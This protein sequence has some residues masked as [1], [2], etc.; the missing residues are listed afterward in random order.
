M[1]ADK[2]VDSTQLD[3]DLT[4]VANA[5][6]AKSG[7]SGQLAFPAG[8]VSEIQA[9]PSG[10]GGSPLTKLTEVTVTANVRS[11]VVAFP[12]DWFDYDFLVIKYDLTPS[13][14]DW[15]YASSTGVGVSGNNTY[16]NVDVTE[17]RYVSSAASNGSVMRVM[18]P[19]FKTANMIVDV[20]PGD[21]LYLFTYSTSKRLVSGSSITVYGGHYADL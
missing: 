19:Y 10:G 15:I 14:K 11:I 9:I 5:I 16:T 8:F 18:L 6:R 2:L 13:A 17:Y 20:A 3:N 12:S 7:G 1:S 21:S 4:S